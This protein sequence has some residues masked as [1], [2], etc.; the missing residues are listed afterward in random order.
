MGYT[1][2]AIRRAL[3]DTENNPLKVAYQLVL[4]HKRML[5]GCKFWL[6]MKN[7]RTHIPS[8]IQPKT[9]TYKA[10]LRHRHRHGIQRSKKGSNRHDRTRHPPH[11]LMN[12]KIKTKHWILP[13]RYLCL[14]QVCLKM[15]H[16]SN[17]SQIG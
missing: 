2:E 4:D 8:H 13:P 7:R 1:H 14:V 17:V 3:T 16:P 5:R 15:T 10:F 11:H 6:A 9:P 12:K